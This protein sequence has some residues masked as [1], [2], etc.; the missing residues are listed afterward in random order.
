MNAIFSWFGCRLKRGARCLTMKSMLYQPN[1]V[2][3]I[4]VR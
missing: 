2:A 1:P 4:S 3:S